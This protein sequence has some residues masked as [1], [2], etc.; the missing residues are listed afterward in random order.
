L[1]RLFPESVPL[2]DLF[3][4]AVAQL[5]ERRPDICLSWLEALNVITPV[6]D[7]NQVY[8][9]V[10]TQGSFGALDDHG[11]GSRPDLIVEVRHVVEDAE[12]ESPIE[13][14]M[15]ESKIGSWE[16]PEQL[17]RYAE[18]L[19][20]MTGFGNKTLLYITRAY[21]PKD[22]EEILSGVGEYVCFEQLRWHDFYRFLQTVEK[23]AFVEEVMTFMEEQGMARSYRFSTVD[24]MALS[25]VPRAFEVFDETLGDEVNTELESFTGNKIGRESRNHMRQ[26][27]RFGRYIVIAPLHGSRFQ[28]LVGYWMRT[29]DGYPEA[30]VQL[31]T[32]PEW[33][34]RAPALAAMQRISLNE[35]WESCNLDNP[36]DW[37]S[38]RRRRSL[39]ALLHEEDHVAAVQ[40]FF[41]ESISQLREELTAFKKERPDLPWNGGT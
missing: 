25:G 1:L 29:A 23:D 32:A 6:L 21:D 26:I 33:I 24:L 9:R 31:E 20:Q 15:V 19:G 37:A 3:T 13:V 22:T 34:G 10:I 4:E 27:R 17:R 2:E 40:R 41:V 38:V 5:L 11:G 16:G 14:V 39:A 12:R 8:I 18:H 30:V 36:A 28:C 7:E 35:D